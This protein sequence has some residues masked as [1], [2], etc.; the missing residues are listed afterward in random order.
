MESKNEVGESREA[1]SR[2]APQGG[3]ADHQAP[4]R[5]RR[6]RE[7]PGAQ[8]WASRRGGATQHGLATDLRLSQLRS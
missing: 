3:Q 7:T 6:I 2:P 4:L 1:S 5:L 8:L